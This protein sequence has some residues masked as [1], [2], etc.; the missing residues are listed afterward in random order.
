MICNQCLLLFPS[1]FQAISSLRAYEKNKKKKFIFELMANNF[2]KIKRLWPRKTSDD[3]ERWLHPGACE[4]KISNSGLF[5]YKAKCDRH[6]RVLRNGVSVPIIAEVFSRCL[7]KIV[8]CNF[9]FLKCLLQ[10]WRSCLKIF[11]A[12]MIRTI[13]SFQTYLLHLI[14]PSYI[15]KNGSF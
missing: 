1:R 15:N 5:R 11:A 6:T 10:Q 2:W 4:K 8:L 9:Q 14:I 3:T 12:W 7:C 13:S